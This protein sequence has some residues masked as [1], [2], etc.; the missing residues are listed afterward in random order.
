MR[1]D[2]DYAWAFAVSDEFRE[3]LREGRFVPRDE[4]SP[5][6]RR[7]GQNLRVSEAQHTGLL[8]GREF[9]GRFQ[10]QNRLNERVAEAL[11]SLKTNFHGWVNSCGCRASANLS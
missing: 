4:Q 9:N 11:V 5:I 2:D 10:P 1:R 7:D 3:V 6:A 8:S